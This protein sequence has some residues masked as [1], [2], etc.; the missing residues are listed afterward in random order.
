LGFAPQSFDLCPI[1]INHY[2]IEIKEI[3]QR[4][5]IR[6]IYC[7][8]VTTHTQVFR[9]QNSGVRMRDPSKK[10]EDWVVWRKGRG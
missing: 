9:S 6:H 4:D 2:F 5:L 1:K 8:F 3:L 10:F 7:L